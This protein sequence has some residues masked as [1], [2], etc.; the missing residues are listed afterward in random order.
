[1]DSVRTYL[2]INSGALFGGRRV[3]FTSPAPAGSVVQLKVDG[4]PVRALLTD[5]PL[6]GGLLAAELQITYL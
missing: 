6:N 3:T 1:M 4:R 5:T 2:V